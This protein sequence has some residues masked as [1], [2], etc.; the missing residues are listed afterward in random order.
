MSS[1]TAW[2]NFLLQRV[3]PRPLTSSSPPAFCHP[4]IDTSDMERDNT[5]SAL[6]KV[7]AYR[8]RISPSTHVSI[9]LTSFTPFSPAPVDDIL[10]SKAVNMASLV[11]TSS[12]GAQTPIIDDHRACKSI[13]HVHGRRRRSLIYTA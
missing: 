11:R 3:R 5:Y 2:H 1:A 13:S 4:L 9:T 7:P 6:L 10:L 8:M 12:H